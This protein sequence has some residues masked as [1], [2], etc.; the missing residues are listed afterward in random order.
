LLAAKLITSRQWR[1]ALAF[2]AAYE[3][4][5]KG[6]MQVGRW[7]AVY[8]DPHCRQ[9][10]PERSEAELDDV[11]LVRGVEAALGGLFPLLIWL[12]VDEFC[13]AELG[14]RLDVD[15]R[16]ARR[17]SAAAVAGLAAAL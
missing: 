5:M 1:S 10:R 14:R 6:A 15:R 3:R 11:G 2:R 17:W 16:T 8:V 4:T 9:P 13:W 7:G 12:T